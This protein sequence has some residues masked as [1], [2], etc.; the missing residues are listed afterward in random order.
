MTL[1]RGDEVRMGRVREVGGGR[2]PGGSAAL[3][4]VDGVMT[5]GR[6]RVAERGTRI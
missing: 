6:G 1:R 5:T 4:G 3:L 2:G